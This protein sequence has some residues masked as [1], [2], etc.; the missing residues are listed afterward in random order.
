M[1]SGLTDGRKRPPVWVTR[2]HWRRIAGVKVPLTAQQAT[3]AG[4][5]NSDMP[6]YWVA[7]VIDALNEAGK[8]LKGSNVL[9]LGRNVFILI[10]HVKRILMVAY[11]GLGGSD[12]QEAP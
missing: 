12:A 2:D 8:P 10:Q 4:E 7:K 9:V 5:I 6:R 1:G 3:L 11:R